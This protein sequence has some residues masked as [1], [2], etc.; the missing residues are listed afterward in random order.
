LPVETALPAISFRPFCS[1]DRD[2]RPHY[3]PLAATWAK[4][5]IAQKKTWHKTN[6]GDFN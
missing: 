2:E 1:S 3:L 5:D 4:I 6:N